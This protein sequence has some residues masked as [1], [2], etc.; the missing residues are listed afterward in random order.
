MRAKKHPVIKSGDR[1]GKWTVVSANCE[2]AP[3]KDTKSLCRCD[4]GHEALVDN[5]RLTLGRSKSCV[6]CAAVSSGE[7]TRQRAARKVLEAS[8]VYGNLTL[9]ATD[10]E[11]LVSSS[12]TK[13]LCRCICGELLHVKRERITARLTKHCN[14][15]KRKAIAQTMLSRGLR[16]NDQEC[17]HVKIPPQGRTYI[18]GKLYAVDGVL[19]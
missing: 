14:K 7:K 2:S 17:D 19:V 12:D 1:F 9:I 11:I 13:L 16:N 8:R 10:D 18:S 4:C 3:Y 5:Y 15:C 6:N